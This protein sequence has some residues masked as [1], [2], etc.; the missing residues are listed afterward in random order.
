MYYNFWSKSPWLKK[1]FYSI[2][3]FESVHLSIYSVYRPFFHLVIPSVQSVHLS[4]HPSNCSVHSSI[5]SV[6]LYICLFISFVPPSVQSV[7]SFSS[8]SHAVCPYIYLSVN[9]SISL[10]VRSVHPSLCLSIRQYNCLSNLS[11]GTT[12]RP[13]VH[14]YYTSIQ[15]VLSS[16]C[17]VCPSVYLFIQTLRISPSVIS[18]DNLIQPTEMTGPVK[19]SWINIPVKPIIR[20]CAVHPSIQSIRPAGNLICLSICLFSPFVHQMD[21][22]TSFFFSE[23]GIIIRCKFF[24][25]F[26]GQKPAR[27]PANKCL[28]NCLQMMAC[29]CAMSSNCVW[30]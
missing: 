21:G 17:S 19:L 3:W 18:R 4:V 26:I 9:L 10:S 24:F 13:S 28:N 2:L 23:S 30:L 22:Q 29:S 20:L 1:V 25:L 12:V 6:R 5:H 14:P 27:W 16:I 8:S 7:H 11:V 15:S